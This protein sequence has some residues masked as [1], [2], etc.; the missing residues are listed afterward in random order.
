[1]GQRSE[2]LSCPDRR[3]RG[4]EGKGGTG[5]WSPG[6]RGAP[7]GH[8]RPRDELSSSGSYRAGAAGLLLCQAQAGF[9]MLD[10]GWGWGGEWRRRAFSRLSRTKHAAPPKQVDPAALRRL[11]RALPCGVGGTGRRPRRACARSWMQRSARWGALCVCVCVGRGVHT[12]HWR[13]LLGKVQLGCGW[14]GGGAQ[15]PERS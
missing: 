7:R 6:W 4:R 14:R 13:L 5:A 8:R 9:A 2:R 3:R 10:G 12:F 11:L 1:M 15:L